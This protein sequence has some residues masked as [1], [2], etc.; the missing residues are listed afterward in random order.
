MGDRDLGI[1][2]FKNKA[3]TGGSVIVPGQG[4]GPVGTFFSPTV[5]SFF[6]QPPDTTVVP[7]LGSD[8]KAANAENLTLAVSVS[9]TVRNPLAAVPGN[10]QVVDLYL[11]LSWQNA[12]ALFGYIDD[13]VGGPMSG[14][15]VFSPEILVDLQYGNTVLLPG[16]TAL[17]PLKVRY[18]ARTN[19]AGGFAAG[20]KLPQFRVNMGLTY[21]NVSTFDGPTYTQYLNNETANPAAPWTLRAASA[22]TVEILKPAMASSLQVTWN[23]YR[24]ATPI[25]LSFSSAGGVVW[26]AMRING[27]TLP[28]PVI[29]WPNGARGVLVTDI[30]AANAMTYVR[31]VNRLSL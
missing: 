21:G 1:L 6:F 22:D 3:N 11:V 18:V 26:G 4:Q 23:D 14:S 17:S 10:L 7:N 24:V 12:K 13:A 15:G 2:G 29:P 9:P 31:I 27:N 19:A 20:T 28:P 8:E 30:D 16:A 5:G 25:D